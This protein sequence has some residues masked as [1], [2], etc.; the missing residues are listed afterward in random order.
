LSFERLQLL[1]Q[2]FHLSLQFAHFF[3]QFCNAISL[4]NC[5]TPTNSTDGSWQML[6]ILSTNS[7]PG[8]GGNP[9][10]GQLVVFALAHTLDVHFD[11]L[12]WF[13]RTVF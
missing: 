8:K 7:Q 2:L 4:R 11:A 1:A 12:D 10:N 13:T 5:G 9:T 3:F 6:Q